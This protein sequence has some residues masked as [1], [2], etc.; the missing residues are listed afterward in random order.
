MLFLNF[1]KSNEATSRWFPRGQ[2]R[3]PS[4]SSSAQMISKPLLVMKSTL[5][6]FVHICLLPPSARAAGRAADSNDDA[7]SAIPERQWPSKPQFPPRMQKF[8]RA[9]IHYDAD[10]ETPCEGVPP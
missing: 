8:V 2:A 5:R 9:V 6:L 7:P 1:F 4:S 10:K 3:R